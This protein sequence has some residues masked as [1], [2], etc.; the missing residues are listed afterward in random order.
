M[1]SKSQA[2]KI[3][4]VGNTVEGKSVSDATS[5]IFSKETFTL[6]MWALAI[7]IV[8]WFGSK[9]FV[10]RDTIT[11]SSDQMVYSQSID[12]VVFGLLILGLIAGYHSLSK[13]DQSNLLGWF[14]KWCRNFYDNP[15]TIV[16]AGIFALV[17]FA[18]V[19]LFR[20]PMTPEAKPVSIYIIEQKV[21]IVFASLFVVMFFKYVLGIP[22]VSILFDNKFVRSLTNSPGTSSSSYSSLFDRWFKKST[23]S[24]S[25]TKSTTLGSTT[26]N[27]PGTTTSNRPGT[28]TSRRPGTTT[29]NQPGTTTSNQPGTTTSNR[30][31][32]SVTSSTPG[33]TPGSTTSKSPN[34]PAGPSNEVFNVT[35]N[36]YTYE[37]AKNVCGAYGARLATYDEV[38]DAY[39]KGGE[40]CNYGWSEGQ[41]AFFPTQKETWKKLQVSESTKNNCGRP[42]VNGGYMANPLLQFG[43]NCF[44][45]KRSPNKQEI[46]RFNYRK[47]HILPNTSDNKAL[48]SKSEYF[49]KQ[50]A[51][52]KINLNSYNLNKWSEY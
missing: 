39:N 21:W 1:S 51:S 32:G 43:A 30:P 48:S 38:E 9:I 34:S 25:P 13:K 22:I 16:E 11:E 28:T 40:W 47:T 2:S 36:I 26:S 3:P 7:Y 46:D 18:M 20:V 12:T 24:P 27:Q 45:K 17:F 4:P 42:G 6:L 41:M 35:E 31:R 5:Q 19:Y 8:I 15:N 10:K 33:S 29:S 49:K 23:T 44:G 14:I 52:G 50:I 37:D